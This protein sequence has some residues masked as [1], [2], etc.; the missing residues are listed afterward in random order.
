MKQ[1]I[2]ND[3]SLTENEKLEAKELLKKEYDYTKILYDEG[4]RRVCKNCQQKCLAKLYCEY[5]IRNYLKS[6]FSSWTSENN[7]INNLIQE[8]QMDS[9]APD[10]IIEWIPY[11][12]LQDIKYL[13]EGGFSE[14]YKAD[15]IGGRYHEWDSKEQQLKRCGSMEIILK[16]LV[17]IERAD[18]I[19]FD[20]AKSHLTISN[21]WP[22]IVKC[23]G[24]TRNPLD[25]KYMLVMMKLDMDLKDY[26]R[27]YHDQLSW[28][29]KIT[30]AY[31]VIN[32]LDSIHKENVVHRDL[33][34][35]NILYNQSSNY[36]LISDLGFCGPVDKPLGGIYGNLPY[37]AP[38]AIVGKEYSF[39]SD[40]YSIAMIMWEISSGQPPFANYKKDYNLA[41]NIVNGKRPTIVSETPLKYVELMKQCW[42]ADP[43]KRPD[44]K[45]LSDMINDIN[46]LYYPNVPT[47][48]NKKNIFRKFLRKFKKTNAN[49]LNNVST[50]EIMSC[51]NAGHASK[52]YNLNNLP[53]PKNATEGII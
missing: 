39:A 7:G 32:A 52:I 24:L 21:K 29:E 40:I 6:K 1:F 9:R 11:N 2:L 47:S 50:S 10:S 17:N 46:R 16:K 3:E 33:H 14:I 42:D 27:Q 43:K 28:N 35:G 13:T 36:W 8:C 48:Y 31:H 19:W 38:E 22:D 20:E 18:R 25:G 12:N 15:W 44:I 53:E 34:S 30:I 41:M 23:Y 49:N 45:M 37:I 26:L 5:C 4:K 51:Y